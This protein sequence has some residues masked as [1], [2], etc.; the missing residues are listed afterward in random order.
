[1]AEDLFLPGCSGAVLFGG[2]AGADLGFR[3][4]GVGVEIDVRVKRAPEN[5]G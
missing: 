5:F 4:G 1:M 3:E 2:K